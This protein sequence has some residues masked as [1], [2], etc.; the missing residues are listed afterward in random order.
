MWDHLTA[1]Q[2]QELD[3]VKPSSQKKSS[4]PYI[5][6][7][8][9]LVYIQ[10]FVEKLKRQF[11]LKATKIYRQ[12]IHDYEPKTSEVDPEFYRARAIGD[13]VW[14][15]GGRINRHVVTQHTRLAGTII[16]VS[17]RPAASTIP[18]WRFP[19]AALRRTLYSLSY[20][21]LPSS[22]LLTCWLARK[23]LIYTVRYYNCSY[24]T[25]CV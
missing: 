6:A 2:L 12:F 13:M 3:R 18:H 16:I 9:R 17:A 15:K 4:R 24:Q 23:W 7:R 19:M 11:D 14:K 1:D 22:F 8:N 10:I 21:R 5:F 20:Q 25:N